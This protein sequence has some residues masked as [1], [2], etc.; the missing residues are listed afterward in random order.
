MRQPWY[1][2]T[3]IWYVAVSIILEQKKAAFIFM[4]KR[5]LIFFADR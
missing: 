4:M 1:M 2:S 3:K 5:P